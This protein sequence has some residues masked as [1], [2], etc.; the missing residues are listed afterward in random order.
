MIGN[1]GRNIFEGFDGDDTLIGDLGVDDLRGGTG[2]DTLAR[3]QLFGVPVADGAID[4][5][6]GFTGTDRCRV[7]QER[8][9]VV[10]MCGAS[11]SLPDGFRKCAGP[12]RGGTVAR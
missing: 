1:K 2:N 7:P 12:T 5:L 6:D 11:S 4:K 9:V 8:M 3:N 10:A